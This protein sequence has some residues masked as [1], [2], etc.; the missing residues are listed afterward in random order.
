MAPKGKEART[1]HFLFH[2]PGVIT[3]AWKAHRCAMIT[4]Y[5]EGRDWQLSVA[6]VEFPHTDNPDTFASFKWVGEGE[7]KWWDKLN[8]DPDTGRLLNP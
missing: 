8:F 5:K 4:V 1:V 6:R 3:G 7:H 2:T